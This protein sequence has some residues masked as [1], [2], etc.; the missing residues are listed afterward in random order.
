MPIGT[1]EQAKQAAAELREKKP[2][3]IFKLPPE[4]LVAGKPIK[5]YNVAS[6]KWEISTGGAGQFLIKACLPGQPYSEPLE[7]PFVIYE[8]LMIDMEH[9]EFRPMLGATFAQ[10]VVGF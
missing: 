7:I 10:S 5:I 4:L 1:V 3:N 8:G 9:I 2:K 6:Q